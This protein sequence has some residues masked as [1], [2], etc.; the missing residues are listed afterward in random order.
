MRRQTGASAGVSCILIR[1]RDEAFVLGTQELGDADL[2]VTLLTERHGKVRAVAR[3]ARRSRRRFGGLLEPMTRVVASWTERAGREL[4]VLDGLEG[5][6]SFAEMQAE[7]VR[8]A[9]CAV[10]AEVASCFSHEGQGDPQEFRLLSA[11]L[12]A[13]ERGGVPS[14]MLRYFEYWTLRV[15]GL[16]PELDVCA[17]CGRPL[18]KGKSTRVGSRHGPLC[19]TC[20]TLPLERESRLTVADRGFLD[21]LRRHPPTDLKT[22]TG[23]G[24]SGSA[25]EIFLRG[26]LEAFVERS[27]KTYRH[28]RTAEALPNDGGPP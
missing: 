21:E 6:R 2:I 25:I 3:A 22:H 23:R 15:H 18:P 27:F 26:T 8:Q 11:V 17:S 13:L 9:A 16:L 7:P 20:P 12:D 28:F 4:H 14:V 10:L 1:Q 24:K 5:R 19:E